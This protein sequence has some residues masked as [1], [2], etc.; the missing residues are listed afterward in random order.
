[1][2]IRLK[3]LSQKLKQESLDCL[4]VA[5]AANI[6]YLVK[7]TSRD[8][9]LLVSKKKSVY[10]TD[11]RYFE[12]VK[13]RLL[14]QGIAVVNVHGP[15]S[16]AIAR[17]C[18]GLKF[19]RIGFEGHVM[20]CLEFKRLVEGLK[21]KARLL[22]SS[23]LV[24]GLRQVKDASEIALIKQ[25]LKITGLTL[26]FARKI[27]RPGKRELEIAAELERFMRFRGA[28]NAA[29]DIIVAS[30]PNSSYPHHA[31]TSRIIRKNEPVLIDIGVEYKGYKSDLTRVYFLGK[32][33][34]LAQRVRKVVGNAQQ[35]AIKEIKPGAKMA[36]I[37]GVSRGYIARLGFGKCFG[38]SLGHGVG[39]ETHEAPRISA[40]SKGVLRP[41]MVFTIE[42]GVYLAGKFGIR[43][44]D[45]VLVTKK[46][47]VVLSGS[48][49]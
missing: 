41:G 39:L 30:G 25:A 42:P 44:E 2:N 33:N 10:F 4:L 22:P 40:A 15:V 11:S 47:C 18:E 49:N 32:I 28:S 46:G 36:E 7:F 9:Y 19:K 48:I 37:D 16:A 14:K 34:F 45:M 29:F 20:T 31:P 27:I 12:E 26:A 21:G 24:E 6:S 5:S 13:P 38:H 3:N 23:G 43:L 35:M 1:M 17:E 8:S